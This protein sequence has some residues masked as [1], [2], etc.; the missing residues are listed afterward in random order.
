MGVPR[1]HDA[2][3]HVPLGPARADRPLPGPARGDPRPHAF[4]P[5]TELWPPERMDRGP[6]PAVHAH[7][8][9]RGAICFLRYGLPINSSDLAWRL[10]KEKSTLIVPGDQFGMDG[11]IRIGMGHAGPYLSEGL[12]RID[13]VLRA[14][15]AEKGAP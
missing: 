4:D 3:A 11:Y 13:G 10:L 7:P 1:L 9:R 12:G 5:P 14:L 8:S 6:W 15:A 2:D